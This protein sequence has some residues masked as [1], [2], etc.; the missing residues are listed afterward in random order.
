MRG[1]CTKNIKCV[2]GVLQPNKFSDTDEEVTGI[3]QDQE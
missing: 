1:H 2:F 3:P